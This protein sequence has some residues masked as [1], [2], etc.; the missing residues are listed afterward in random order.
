MKIHYLIESEQESAEREAVMDCELYR[1]VTE[2]IDTHEMVKLPIR[3]DRRPRNAALCC[4][5][6]FNAFFEMVHGDKDVRSRSMFCSNVR[7]DAS[8]YTDGTGH[9]LQVY[10]LKTSKAA[11]IPNKRDSLDFI[12]AVGF[13]FIRALKALF[14]S[15]DNMD[16]I[17]V[18]S[19]LC[20]SMYVGQ[21][22]NCL[23]QVKAII[24]T[25]EGL[26]KTDTERDELKT[27]IQKGMDLLNHYRVIPATQLNSAS[28][29][30]E[31]EFMV[32]DAPYFYGKI[33]TGN[34]D[35]DDIPY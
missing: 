21:I 30:G 32:F 5:I 18:V 12:E 7:L 25:V 19:N 33:T 13:G 24:S 35:D 10:P 31:A 26:C 17:V 27:A 20:G 4:Q 2:N 23:E 28:N 6:V 22:T 9:V 16:R 29:T 34:I 3:Q 14:S 8:S 15:D 11:Y 1:G